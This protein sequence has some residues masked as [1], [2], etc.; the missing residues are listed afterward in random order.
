[1]SVV[2]TKETVEAEL[3]AKLKAMI[4]WVIEAYEGRDV[5]YRHSILR[6]SAR[7]ATSEAWWLR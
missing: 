5:A 1:M 7:I 6:G 2:D 3:G 4:S